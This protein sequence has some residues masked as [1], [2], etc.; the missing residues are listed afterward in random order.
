MDLFFSVKAIEFLRHI[1]NNAIR[2]RRLDLNIC[3]STTPVIDAI[4][5]VLIANRG[6]VFLIFLLFFILGNV[7]LEEL[8]VRRRYVG[9]KFP[10]LAQLIRANS[11]TLKQIGKIGLGEAIEAFTEEV[12]QGRKGGD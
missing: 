3:V 7:Q 9:N 6:N 2:I 5:G 8:Y 1:L 11:K 12:G 10:L 4:L